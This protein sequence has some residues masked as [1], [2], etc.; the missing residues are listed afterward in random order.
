MQ[1]FSRVPGLPDFSYIYFIGAVL[2]FMGF[3]SLCTKVQQTKSV[4]G[5][6]SQSVVM[7]CISLGLRLYVTSVHEGYLPSDNTGDYM[8]QVVDA[9]TFVLVVSMLYTIHKTYVYTYA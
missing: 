3:F 7:T 8:L 2:Q 5:I 6:S 1:E 4:A 9:C